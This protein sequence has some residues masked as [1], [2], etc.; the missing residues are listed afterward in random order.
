VYLKALS[1]GFVNFEDQDYVINNT[2]IRTLGREFWE[3]AFTTVPVNYWVPLLW[4]SYALDY[5]FWGLNPLGYHLTNIILH[6]SNAGLVVLVAHELYKSGK[7]TDVGKLP[8][9]RFLY[10]GM[11][12]LAG[13]LFGI[14]PARVESVVWV[15]ERKDVLNGLFTLGSIFFYLRYQ[16]VKEE[17]RG[18]S[19]LH[20]AYALSIGLF[21]CSLLAK[22]SSLILP[23]SLLVIDMYPL[24]RFRTGNLLSILMEKIPYFTISSAV[25]LVS[26]FHI[27]NA[28][29]FNSLSELPFNV[30][31]IAAGNSVYEY[32][33]L[34]IYPVNIL[35]YYDLPRVIPKTYIFS[36]IAVVCVICLTIGFFNKV[37]RVSAIIIFFIVTIFPALHFFAGGG[38]LI[39]ASRYTYLPSLIPSIIL[40]EMIASVVDKFSDYR[41]RYVR[42][43]ILGLVTFLVVFYASVTQLQI[44]VWKDSGTMWSKVIEFQ[45][46][47][48]AY[49]SRGLYYFDT[50][51]YSKA[52]DDYSSCISMVSKMPIPEIFNLYAFRGEA[53]FKAGRLDD[54]VRDFDFAITQFPH[55]LYYYH[56]GMALAEMG[57]IDAAEHDLMR[58]GRAKGQMFWFPAGSPTQ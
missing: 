26:V 52:V 24:H 15:T 14:H 45:P 13:I 17:M 11:L 19:S 36:S 27:H 35:P 6:A 16:Q 37:P 39:L 28:E 58:A 49:F 32:F 4:L 3:W 38:Q 41:Y 9:H 47:D 43:G 29:G 46:F 2:G 55:Q 7:C 34:M 8:E 10:I 40:A 44:G 23:V 51:N 48:K 20:S 53:L 50:G 56:R 31:I 5:H 18:R 42:F 25:A 30:R 33:K 57:K 1:C 12:M 22:P 21:F 54:A